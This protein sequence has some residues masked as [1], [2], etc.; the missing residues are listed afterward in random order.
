MFYGFLKVQWTVRL[1]T[2]YFDGS[3][4]HEWHDYNYKASYNIK[5]SIDASASR[6]L[7]SIE[8][9]VDYHSPPFINHAP[10]QPLFHCRIFGTI[11]TLDHT[12]ESSIAS[13]TLPALIFAITVHHSGFPV[14]SFIV[15]C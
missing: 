13:P 8:L 15:T 7:H 2:V 10:P 4:G 6:D 11:I 12:L 14:T 3:L 1:R 5:T 9:L